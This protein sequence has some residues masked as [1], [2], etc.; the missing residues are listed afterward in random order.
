RRSDQHA[1]LRV[2]DLDVDTADDMR[3]AEMLV[4]RPDRYGCQLSSCSATRLGHVAQYS[5]R[6]S[7]SLD[8]HIIRSAGLKPAYD[9]LRRF[10]PQLD[11]GLRAE[12]RGMR[13][14]DHLR[15]AEQRTL[16]GD[17]LDRQY[18]QSGP[19]KYSTIECR[20]QIVNIDDCAACGIHDVRS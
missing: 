2:G 1:E 5:S 8:D 4:N 15:M 19:G 14:Q 10:P 18:V 17:R 12:E 3:R 16:S 7:C 11:L 20:K 9:I 6:S 13:R